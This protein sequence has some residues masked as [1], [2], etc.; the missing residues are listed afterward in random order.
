MKRKEIEK[1]ISISHGLRKSNAGDEA[2][3][4]LFMVLYFDQERTII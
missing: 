2:K 3:Y 1:K 4:N